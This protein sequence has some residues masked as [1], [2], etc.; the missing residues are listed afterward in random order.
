MRAKWMKI[1]K[2]LRVSLS[3]AKANFILR[4]EGSYLGIFWYLLN[5]LALFYIILFI[6]KSAFAGSP[7]PHYP[8]YLMIGI[9][10]LNFFRQVISSSI[11][12]IA[13]S[14]DYIKS[15]NNIAP[16]VLVLSVVFQSALS[17]F[18]E[19]ILMIGFMIYWRIPLLGLLFYPFIFA[20]FLLLV[21][22][23]AFIFA[24][25]GVYITDIDNI[26]SIFAQLLLFITPI[27]YVATPG[28]AVYTANLFN[29]LFY[30]LEISRRLIIYSEWPPAW[31]ALTML[32]LSLSFFV[33]GLAVFNKYKKKFAELV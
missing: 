2:I 11:Q 26:W 19:F 32:I 15:M 14:G 10:G 17:H 27:F 29:P 23:I 20:L 28:S 33:I 16:E 5:P 4:I 13:A 12:S 30:F 3:L 6:Q 9:I 7:T 24:A 8:A 25:V 22:G 31:M 18:F 1:L 21:I